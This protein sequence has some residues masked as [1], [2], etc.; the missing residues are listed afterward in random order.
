VH[1]M[2]EKNYYC[3]W[4]IILLF[5]IWTTNINEAA[6][7]SARQPT[8]RPTIKPTQNPLSRTPS[9]FPTL[10]KSSFPTGAAQFAVWT[11]LSANSSFPGRQWHTS[12]YDRPSSTVYTIG[13]TT[14]LFLNSNISFQ[15]IWALNTLTSKCLMNT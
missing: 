8:R 5:S 11:Q 6:K 14:S 7:K 13:G 15:D 2:K 10:L 12:V 4:I 9:I 3:Y 1:I